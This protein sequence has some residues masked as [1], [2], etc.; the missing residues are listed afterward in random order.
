[1]KRWTEEQITDSVKDLSD[2]TS[3]R[4]FHL[5][6]S[7]A[8]WTSSLLCPGCSHSWQ[9]PVYELAPGLRSDRPRTAPCWPRLPPLPLRAPPPLPQRALGTQLHPRDWTH[10]NI[11]GQTTCAVVNGLVLVS[12]CR[13]WK[14]WSASSKQQN[15]RTLQLLRPCWM[16]S[17]ATLQGDRK[18]FYRLLY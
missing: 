7:A 16:M 3:L 5:Q 6:Q 15:P 10:P 13:F 2:I 4:V 9:S 8:V 11:S 17:S 14:V 1:M 12:D 18:H